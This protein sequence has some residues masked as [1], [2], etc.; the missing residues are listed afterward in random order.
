M[1]RLL[2]P[3]EFGLV[4]MANTLTAL[5]RVFRDAGLSVATIQKE[6]ITQ[7]QVS[8]LF[9]ANLFVGSVVTLLVMTL[10]PAVAIFYK[11]PQLLAITFWVSF[12]FLFGSV[13]AQPRA[14]LQRKM[15]FRDLGLIDV[16]SST[17]SVVVGV[18][19]ALHGFGV[20]SLVGLQLSMSAADLVLTT[21][22]AKWRPMLPRRGIGTRAM[23]K[24][25]ASLTVASFLRQLAQ[26]SD[27]ILIGRF[28]GPVA[29]G[30]YSRALV[31]LLRP[32]QQFLQPL[33]SVFLPVLS[34]VQNDPERF[35][36]IFLRAYRA[37]AL[38][39]FPIAGI[40]YS[41]GDLFV[42][43]FLGPRWA[44]VIPIFKWLAVAALFI[45]VA[46]AGMW[47]LTT[48]G[49]SKLILFTGLLFSVLMILSFAVGVHFGPI[50]VA[51]AYGLGWLLIR[52]PIQNLI[53]GR[54]G[55]IS[56]LD[57]WKVLLTHL[58][59]CGVIIAATAAARL[60]V[61]H[62]SPIAQLAV[63]AMAGVISCF[64]FILAVPY[65]RGEAVFL[66]ESLKPNK[67]K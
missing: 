2:S 53:V 15:L 3:K 10:A 43:V 60:L 18:F 24:F 22:R 17:V 64:A 48:Q 57:L 26:S 67:G 46:N 39:S 38:I 52:M 30:L 6:G 55:L 27:T 1:A 34:R 41:L 61:V 8:N 63:S 16:G 49:R 59:V 54:L 33:E 32:V 50:G 35:R 14:M 66:L 7:A 44:G 37:I 9:W 36:R 45:P 51:I 28:W 29:T 62:L 56:A 11:E 20:W 12:T 23:L 40:L 4:A 5:L 21:S 58:P 25:G 42:N 19:M 47:I 13:A 65:L 31:L